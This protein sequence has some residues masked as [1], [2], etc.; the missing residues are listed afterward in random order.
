MKT[1]ACA[2]RPQPALL[3][4][5]R[6][7]HPEVA[8]GAGAVGVH[9]AGAA[10]VVSGHLLD[11]QHRVEVGQSTAAVLDRRGH[12]EQTLARKLL[13]PPT[14]LLFGL[15]FERVLGKLVLREIGHHAFDGQL[16][17]GQWHRRHPSSG[18]S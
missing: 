7:E 17:F 15:R 10:R 16:V 8:G 5:G 13:E 6:A 3:L 4:L 14:V 12:A 9:L 11:C 18:G 2:D 1:S